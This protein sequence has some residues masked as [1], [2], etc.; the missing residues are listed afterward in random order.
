MPKWSATVRQNDSEKKVKNQGPSYGRTSLSKPA[1]VPFLPRS[2][3]IGNDR[4]L[5]APDPAA[6]Y[7]GQTLPSLQERA[8]GRPRTGSLA[9]GSE[10]PATAH[11][12]GSKTTQMQMP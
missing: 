6:G 9:V 4:S 2:A 8:P 11:I 3:Y 1:V 7:P 5:E 12:R 10:R